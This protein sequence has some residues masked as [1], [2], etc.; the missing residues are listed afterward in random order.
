[1]TALAPAPPPGP[2]DRA[3]GT[4]SAVTPG[5]GDLWRRYRA[6][7]L[8][9]AVLVLV[10]LAV[11]LGARP[12]RSGPLEP[13]ST[14]PDGASAL[15]N[16]IGE[17]GGSVDVERSSEAA[18]DTLGAGDSAVLSATHRLSAGELDRLAATGAH[19]VVVQPTGPAL[20]ALAPGTEVAG[21][22]GDG[23]REPRCSAPAAEAAGAARTG[24][25]T[26]T[27]DD[28]V[29]ACYPGDNGH[30]VLTAERGNGA[31]TTVIGTPD[32]FTN[33]Y[34]AREGNAALLLNLLRSGGGAAEAERTVWIMPDVPAVGGE[35]SLT[36][37]LPQQ[38]KSA[39]VPLGAAL[40]LLAFQQ[41]R[42]LGPLVQE[43]LPVV[44]RAAETTEGR[45][46]LYA[47][48][49]ARGPAAA[50]LRTA[51]A[52]RIRPRLGLTAQ[53]GPDEVAA[54]VADRTGGEPERIRTLLYGPRPAPGAPG[55]APGGP[56]RPDG[57]DIAGDSDLVALADEL[58]RLEEKLQ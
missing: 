23:T 40:L 14:E 51:T 45:A 31:P 30:A 8:V 11:S 10:A 5:L 12:E 46:R 38:L 37:L 28:P 39:L 52:D 4:G 43:R 17:A 35:K 25:E 18:A 44:V 32:P 2:P 26:Y 13:E 49:R 58:D 54:A 19:L 24:G 47:G 16:V 27:G 3:A 36:D 22:T 57:S 1:M 20:D 6:V 15:V 53:A 50:A 21:N 48:R 55:S 34:L 41:G 29:A 7:A 42:R 56:L 33:A 9:G